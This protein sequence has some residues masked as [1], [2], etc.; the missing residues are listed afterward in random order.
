M[1]DDIARLLRAVNDEE[2]PQLAAIAARA[3]WNVFDGPYFA[4]PSVFGLAAFGKAGIDSLAELMD[5]ATQDTSAGLW[6]APTVLLLIALNEPT[7]AT[8][9]LGNVVEFPGFDQDDESALTAKIRSVCSDAKLRA[10][11]EK[12]LIRSL[13]RRVGNPVMFGNIVAGCRRDLG[14]R[15]RD[16][17]RI[18]QAATECAHRVKEP[19]GVMWD[20]RHLDADLAE[21]AEVTIAFADMN[22]LKQINDLEGHAA[23]DDAIRRYLV[24]VHDVV[25]AAGICYR[26]GGDEVVISFPSTDASAARAI[27]LS[28]LAKLGDSTAPRILTASCG[29]AERRPGESVDGVLKRADRAMYVAKELSKASTPRKSAVCIDG[30]PPTAL[31]Q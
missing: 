11:A 18:A 30:H 17:D 31:D 23:G 2:A 21:T 22:G 27:V 3:P 25:G 20:G 6:S 7:V 13:A 4:D 26:R 24:V 9:H 8:R 10:Y 14:T 12:R 1:G 28:A 15:L 29:L 19:F 16:V 5:A